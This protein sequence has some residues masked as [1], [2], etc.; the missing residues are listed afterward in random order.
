M[1]KPIVYVPMI[2]RPVIENKTFHTHIPMGRFEPQGLLPMQQPSYQT[3]T[4]D[5]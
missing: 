1:Q 5:L 2:Y 4:E 3:V